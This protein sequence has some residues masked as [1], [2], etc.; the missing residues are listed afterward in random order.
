MEVRIQENTRNIRKYKRIQENVKNY[1]CF[2]EWLRHETMCCQ[3]S[4]SLSL[5][6][7]N[8]TKTADKMAVRIAGPLLPPVHPH[9]DPVTGL[10]GS[11]VSLW[12]DYWERSEIKPAVPQLITKMSAGTNLGD[13]DIIRDH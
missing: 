7:S 3:N 12:V 2:G 9:Q 6:I 11:K 8:G 13:S 4:F 1:M 5:H 10:M